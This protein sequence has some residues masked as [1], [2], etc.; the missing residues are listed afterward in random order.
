MPRAVDPKRTRKALA[1]VRRLAAR[2]PVAETAPDAAEPGFSDPAFSGWEKEFLTEVE[3]RLDTY[4]S[5]FT[6]PGKGSLE[7]ALSVLQTQ[8]LKEIER[9]AKGRA[10]DGGA[11]RRPRS[12]FKRKPPPWARPAAQDP[13][14]GER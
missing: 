12:S 4:G 5:A 11:D 2:S 9:K 13:D 7:D 6:D 3:K 14:E 10:P 8:K 1:R